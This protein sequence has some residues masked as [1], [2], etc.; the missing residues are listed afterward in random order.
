MSEDN[1]SGL[2]DIGRRDYVRGLAAAGGI[3]ALGLSGASGTAGANTDSRRQEAYQNRVDSADVLVDPD[4]EHVT[5]R[6]AS[7]SLG[8]EA[9]GRYYGVYCKGLDG[10]QGDGSI[11]QA[12]YDAV[13]DT[14]ED[15]TS[16]I[17]DFDS[18]PTGG[19]RQLVAPGAGWNY[20]TEGLDPWMTVIDVPNGYDSDWTAV[21]MIDNYWMSYFRDVN[22][23]DW[24]D[25]EEAMIAYEEDI[26]NFTE[27]FYKSRAS[28]PPWVDTSQPFRGGLD[29][30]RTGP[31]LSQFFT[32]KAVNGHLEYPI[33]VAELPRDY[34]RNQQE[35]YDVASGASEGG[36]EPGGGAS[37]V[38]DRDAMRW[39][40][41]GRDLAA[42][43]RDDPGYQ[44]YLQAATQLFAW[45]CPFDEN[46]PYQ[47]DSSTLQYITFGGA[48]V[49]DLLARA[50]GNALNAAWYH[51]WLRHRRARPETYAANVAA[52]DP[53]GEIPDLLLDS[54]G[55]AEAGPYLSQAYPEGAPAHPAYPSGH[56]CIAGACATVLKAVF[57]DVEFSDLPDLDQWG[58]K[59]PTPRNGEA[60]DTSE[61]VSETL[62][63]HGEINKLADNIGTGRMWAGVHYWSDHLWGTALGEQVA[64]ATMLDMLT[65]DPSA[66]ETAVSDVTFTN[67]VGSTLN[68]TLYDLNA[69]RTDASGYYWYP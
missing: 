40:S 16:D 6:G 33:Q 42:F 7:S 8:V 31:Y 20:V 29:G 45:G 60:P 22:F 58:G 48:S 52:G 39:I 28:P 27:R 32:H 18:I 12:E 51:K 9:N 23:G 69:Q 3:T 36:A 30:S 21:E 46:L 11:T 54:N 49:L 62:T 10:F 41:T 14:L 44:P 63:V 26:D 57:A 68:L 50:A 37:D 1:D 15:P 47:G 13:V 24:H 64:M 38:A 61:D 43:V 2:F 53:T 5:P 4:E 35:Y 66:D 55:L 34:M 25:D 56:S 59:N 19:N 65:E 17:E 67:I